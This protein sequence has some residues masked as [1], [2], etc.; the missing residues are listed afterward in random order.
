MTSVKV[1]D[2]EE[3]REAIIDAVPSTNYMHVVPDNQYFGELE[4]IHRRLHGLLGRID[5]PN[6]GVNKDGFCFLTSLEEDLKHA[7]IGIENSIKNGYKMINEKDTT[8]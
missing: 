5:N 2:T 3:E 8:I 1:Y 4:Q 7:I 6:R